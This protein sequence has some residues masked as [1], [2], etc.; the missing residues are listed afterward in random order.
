MPTYA[1]STAKELTDEHRAKLV[2]SITSSGG[3]TGAIFPLQ[4]RSVRRNMKCP[5]RGPAARQL[6]VRDFAID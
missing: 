6:S 5:T 2:E 1:F 3:S 4:R